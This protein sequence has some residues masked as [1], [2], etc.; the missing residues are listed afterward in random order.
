MKKSFIGV[1]LLASCLDLSACGSG[2]NDSNSDTK[3]NETSSAVSSTAEVVN[4]TRNQTDEVSEIPK[5]TAFDPYQEWKEER[6]GDSLV[7]NE[8][9]SCTWYGNDYTYEYNEGNNKISI[10]QN[11]PVSVLIIEEDDIFKLEI[12]TEIYVPAKYYDY[13]HE[14]AVLEALEEE[15][16]GNTVVTVGDKTML[17]C[18]TSFTLDKVELDRAEGIFY[19][20]LTCKNGTDEGCADFESL[21]CRWE[22]CGVG[23]P[24]DMT[25][26]ERF[27]D[28][29]A[30]VEICLELKPTRRSLESIESDSAETYGYIHLEFTNAKKDYYIN[31]N[32]FFNAE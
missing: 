14:K 28:V 8:D 18:G 3:P 6:F 22:S 12:G 21:E 23:C 16:N 7:L 10:L 19:V 26:G 20:Y 17:P 4:T 30:S 1:L 32:D 25:S 31:I 29:G 15:L 5:E 27:V 11:I 2:K 24:L 13:F 9:K